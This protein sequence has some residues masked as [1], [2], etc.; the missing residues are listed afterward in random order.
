MPLPKNSPLEITDLLCSAC[1]EKM[2]MRIK[3]AG[4]G[5]IE[6]VVYTCNTPTCNYEHVRSVTYSR[7]QERAIKPEKKTA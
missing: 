3:R 4:R 2:T 6:E 5:M 7:G 1:G